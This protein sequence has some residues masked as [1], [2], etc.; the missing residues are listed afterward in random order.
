[1]GYNNLFARFSAPLAYGLPKSCIFILSC[2]ALYLSSKRAS[3]RTSEYVLNE[4][5]K[6]KPGE[7]NYTFF[8]NF[9]FTT[10]NQV[11]SP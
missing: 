5:L 2:F 7:L 6:P 8:T 4:M 11:L 10:N 1:M 3:N 9:R